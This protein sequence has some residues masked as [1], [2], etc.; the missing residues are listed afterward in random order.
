M[1]T[2]EKLLASLVHGSQLCSWLREPKRNCA[3]TFAD[4]LPLQ[5]SSQVVPGVAMLPACETKSG[6]SKVEIG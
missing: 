2:L 6:M 1:V 5:V 3:E 4:V